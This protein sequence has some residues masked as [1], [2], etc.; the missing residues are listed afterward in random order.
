ML[1]PLPPPCLTGE[2]G[3]S[4][5]WL[6]PPPHTVDTMVRMRIC[7]LSTA[8][9]SDDFVVPSTIQA[10]IHG[11]VGTVLG[12]LAIAVE[13]KRDS[14]CE[15][16][17][18][19]W[20]L[21]G[22]VA[23]TFLS[24]TASWIL[25]QQ[26]AKGVIGLQ[27]EPAR[28]HVPFLAAFTG[29][30][31]FL[32]V[33]VAGTSIFSAF[34]VSV[35][36]GVD[37]SLCGL[38]TAEVTLMKLFAVGY[39]IVTA[40]QTCCIVGFILSASVRPQ[41]AEEGWVSRIKTLATLCCCRRPS[42]AQGAG[43]EHSHGHVMPT[44][45]DTLLVVGRVLASTLGSVQANRLT[46][47]DVMAGL[48]LLR[49]IQAEHESDCIRGIEAQAKPE[50]SGLLGAL[51]AAADGAGALAPMPV[52]GK[53]VPAYI[54]PH[55]EYACTS[56][57]AFARASGRFHKSQGPDGHDREGGAGSG[58]G[59][60]A[61]VPAHAAS[62]DS[63]P[64]LATI[65]HFAHYTT[66]AYGWPLYVF[67]GF[68]CGFCRLAQACCKLHCSQ[69]SH[70]R[71]CPS[72][73]CATTAYGVHVRS[74]QA[75]GDCCMCNT[76]GLTRQLAGMRGEGGLSTVM[77]AWQSHSR[78]AIMLPERQPS[79]YAAHADERTSTLIVAS[80]DNRWYSPAF[81]VAL[82]ERTGSI[83]ITVRGTL[84][85]E[86]C[87][88][89]VVAHPV[90][91]EAEPTAQALAV[92]QGMDSE[93]GSNTESWFAHRGMWTSATSTVQRLAE[94]G[95]LVAT[96]DGSSYSWGER[97]QRAH[98]AWKERQGPGATV[99][100]GFG[101]VPASPAS[102][103]SAALPPLVLIGHSLGAGV[104]T[105]LTVLLGASFPGL[106]TFAYSPPAAVVSPELS[107]VLRPI[108]TSV[109]LGR[110]VVARGTLPVIQRLFR[111]ITQLI[112][113]AEISKHDLLADSLQPAEALAHARLHHSTS[114][115]A[116]SASSIGSR[117]SSHP[118][119]PGDGQAMVLRSL[120]EVARYGS[121]TALPWVLEQPQLGTAAAFGPNR[122]AAL[123]IVQEAGLF[124][125]A[126]IRAS[127]PQLASPAAAETQLRDADH[128]MWVP[129]RV[130]HI[131][132]VASVTAMP[133]FTAAAA[134]SA[135]AAAR[136]RGF[137]E[138]AWSLTS[139]SCYSRCCGLPVL[140]SRKRSESHP[141]AVP[142]VA[143][144]ASA[145]APGSYDSAREAS[146]GSAAA[147]PDAPQPH[148]SLRARAQSERYPAVLAAPLLR[149]SEEVVATASLQQVTPTMRTGSSEDFGE[150]GSHLQGLAVAQ[151]HVQAWAL[152]ATWGG[153]LR[154]CC[155][156]TCSPVRHACY[157]TAVGTRCT[158]MCWGASRRGCGCCTLWPALHACCL[159]CAGA[160]S[161]APMRVLSA[162]WVEPE[163]FMCMGPAVSGSMLLDHFPDVVR[164]AVVTLVGAA[165][166]DNPGH[167]SL[168]L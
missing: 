19:H 49:I 35:G 159:Q 122:L 77:R 55:W 60:P 84:S 116:S 26:S 38:N 90:S 8:F 44:A 153:C 115:R 7:G 127:T 13:L 17:Y 23:V 150:A 53:P 149:G 10:I 74:V 45:I 87:I 18:S 130:L 121:G 168:H 139:R 54:T 133:E 99:L 70:C 93:A 162:Y 165:A 37:L 6:A 51:E 50:H 161:M 66:A 48:K 71:Q 73:C 47:S 4:Q 12:I 9:S 78:R 34:S 29:L 148:K 160:T 108:V 158:R 46:V 156:R 32:Q 91:L 146:A 89:D 94:L 59:V 30:L 41:A 14:T 86:D 103:A 143:G 65:A 157:R 100:T 126:Q 166:H 76:S 25:A 111:V 104:A 151:L 64:S 137:S 105:M 2:V 15:H 107:R 83:V 62:L 155:V 135:L 69:C 117:H 39:A 85:L 79:M 131:V 120:S 36:D 125:S 40:I 144:A 154:R 123:R 164:D 5:P 1:K 27:G 101:P 106:R 134:A 31:G 138:P 110:D 114:A 92:Q 42:P 98:A 58:A 80:W 63:A 136:Q 82:D 119:Q 3:Q 140:C 129:G 124:G 43:T 102:G 81:Y 57:L 67:E 75:V 20:L 68:A 88:T 72:S 24:M 145:G 163:Q 132:K 33:L 113:L 167:G 97:I 128:D 21:F 52:P 96:S 61:E 152:Y 22:A 11:I 141:P 16:A 112:P 28:R 147:L 118:A 95:V 109:V 142:S 56:R